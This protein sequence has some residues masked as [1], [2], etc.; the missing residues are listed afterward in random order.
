MLP[1]SPAVFF[2]CTHNILFVRRSAGW[3][4]EL[5]IYLFIYFFAAMV[6]L[7]VSLSSKQSVALLFSGPLLFSRKLLLLRSDLQLMNI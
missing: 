2:N 3:T 5:L 4:P 1:V 6:K 7:G